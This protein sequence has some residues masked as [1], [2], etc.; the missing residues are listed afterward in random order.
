MGLQINFNILV[1]NDRIR[2][3]IPRIIGIGCVSVA[4]LTNWAESYVACD[5]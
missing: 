4:C 5:D 3:P 2:R 1:R